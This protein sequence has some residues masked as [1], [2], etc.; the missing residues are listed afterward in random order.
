[1]VGGTGVRLVTIQWSARWS[2]NAVPRPTYD[3]PAVYV[4][5]RAPSNGMQFVVPPKRDLTY[6]WQSYSYRTYI[7]F[8]GAATGTPVHIGLGWNNVGSSIDVD[9][10]RI[11]IAYPIINT[12]PTK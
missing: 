6:Q 3:S 4:D 7:K 12:M 8:P 2:Y 11:S 5:L 10:L 9:C 1:M